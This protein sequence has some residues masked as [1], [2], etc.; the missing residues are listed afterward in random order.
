MSPRDTSVLTQNT[1]SPIPRSMN[2][3]IPEI[4]SDTR[5]ISDS[6]LSVRLPASSTPAATAQ[7]AEAPIRMATAI[8][9]K[10]RLPPL[11]LLIFPGR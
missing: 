9:A 4:A 11:P 1:F 7:Y 10:G 8:S 2:P 3:V 6:A 5:S